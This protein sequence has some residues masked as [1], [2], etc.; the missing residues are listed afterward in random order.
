M[1][2][3]DIITGLKNAVARG[4]SLQ[5][6][7]QILINSGYNPIEV[8]EASRYIQGGIIPY[9]EPKKDEYLMMIQNKMQNNNLNQNSNNFKPKELVQYNPNF[10]NQKLLENSQIQEISVSEDKLEIKEKKSFKK[11]IILLVILLFFIAILALTIFFKDN[12]L[13]FLSG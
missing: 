10:Q 7:V 5:N 6:A 1:V 9:L 12:I 3:E 8:N 2:N 11:E 13:N 4:E